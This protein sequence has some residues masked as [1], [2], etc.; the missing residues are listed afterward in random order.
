MMSEYSS[1]HMHFGKR[2]E[3]DYVYR[4]RAGAINCSAVTIGVSL[5]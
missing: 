1:K 2:T 3:L 4:S 5:H